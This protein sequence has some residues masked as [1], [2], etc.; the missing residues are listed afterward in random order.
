MQMK[1]C[2]TMPKTL[3]FDRSVYNAVRKYLIKNQ[4]KKI[5]VGEAL[6]EI[7]S[8]RVKPISVECVIECIRQCAFYR[9]WAGQPTMYIR[10]SIVYLNS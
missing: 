10:G 5:P 6:A 1:R 9:E 8:G 7:N 2:G 3:I 4:L